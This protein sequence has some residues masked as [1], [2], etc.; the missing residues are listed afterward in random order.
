[1][2]EFNE[3]PERQTI[4][5]CYY[6]ASPIYVNG[7]WMNIFPTTILVNTDTRESLQLISA[8]NVPMSPAK[9]FSNLQDN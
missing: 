7:G 5:H 6:V 1:M 2:P 8:I 3:T 4:I 9:F